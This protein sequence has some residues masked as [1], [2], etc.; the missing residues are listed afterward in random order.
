[1]YTSLQ[2]RVAKTLVGVGVTSILTGIVLA[3]CV[4]GGNPTATPA[5]L[6]TP[7]PQEIAAYAQL[8][9]DETLARGRQIYTQYCASCH[10]INGEGQFPDSY[11]YIDP[12]TGKHGAAPQDETGHTM[13][14]DD[15]LLYWYI[16]NGGVAKPEES[17]PMPGY[18]G[19]L[20]D[21][22]VLDVIAFIKSL[23]TQEQR[24]MQAD[25]TLTIRRQN[26]ER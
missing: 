18:S 24:Y 19:I 14:H 23:W 21:E 16:M 26:Q 10:G 13:H 2:N 7:S 22:N 9:D 5:A 11:D 8:A 6:G 1:M 17:Y 15:D 25:T 3:S 20:S 4:S 12:A